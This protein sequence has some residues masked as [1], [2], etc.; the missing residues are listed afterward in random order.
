VIKRLLT[1]LTSPRSGSAKPTDRKV[2]SDGDPI[3]QGLF[4]NQKMKELLS[5][6]KLNGSSGPFHSV[7]EASRLVDAGKKGEAIALLRGIIEGSA[8]ETR[9]ELWVWSCLRELGESPD[10][11]AGHEIL[12]VVLE[13]PSGGAYDT[14]SAY[15]DGTARYLNFSGAAIFWDAPDAAIK[16]LCLRFIAATVAIAGKAV[17]RL[18]LSLPKKGFQATLLTRSGI[19]VVTNPPEAIIGSGGSLMLELIKRTKKKNG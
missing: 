18:S 11:H 5:R 15:A 3:R 10:P 7:A 6:V 1:F 9:V 12:G 4:A 16:Q 14:L 19:Y 8:Q 17:P 2:G 13:M